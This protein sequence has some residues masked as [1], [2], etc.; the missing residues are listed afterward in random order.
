[1]ENLGGDCEFTFRHYQSVLEGALKSGYVFHDHLTYWRQQPGG[2]SILLRHDIDNYMKRA[3]EF[4]RIEAALGLKATYFVRIHAEY[5]PFY[6]NDYMRLMEIQK[7]GHELALHSDVLEF[8]ALT[9]QSDRPEELLVRE[10]RYLET[11]LDSKVYGI[12]THRDLNS[13]VP[14]SMPWVSSLDLSAFGLE[15]DAY[16][17][18]FVQERKYVS[19]KVNRGIGWWE[20][21]AC[22]FIDTDDRLTILTHPRWW[23]HQHFY[24]D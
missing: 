18:T 15:Y 9:G 4:A 10:V 8:A 1:M 23:Y 13:G 3:V 6:V 24:E 5:N 21:C 14:N 19:E 2:R 22:K 20:K 17:P 16:H 7:L 11:A 12:A